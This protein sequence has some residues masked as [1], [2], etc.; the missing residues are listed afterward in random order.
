M[1]ECPMSHLTSS[2]DVP[3]FSQGRGARSQQ[4]PGSDAESQAFHDRSPKRMPNLKHA[5]IA[6]SLPSASPTWCSISASV[7]LQ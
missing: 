6:L 7:G 3:H 4:P 5:F 2:H 1:S